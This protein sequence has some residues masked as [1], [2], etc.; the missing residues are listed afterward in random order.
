[1]NKI[2]HHPREYDV[3]CVVVK[4]VANYDEDA[5]RMK[6]VLLTLCSMKSMVTYEKDFISS[7]GA[8]IRFSLAYGRLSFELEEVQNNLIYKGDD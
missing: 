5:S 2:I 8:W 3:D 4:Y 6:K 1:M 7:P